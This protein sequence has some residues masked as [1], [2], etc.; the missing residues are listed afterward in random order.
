MGVGPFLDGIFSQGAFGIVTQM[1]I[2]LAPTPERVEA[3][4]F[5][6]P[7]DSDMERAVEAVRGLSREVG[8]ALGLVNLL[9]A[10]RVLSMIEPYPRNRLDQ[11]GLIDEQ[12][13][14]NMARHNQV[15]PWMGTGAI[16]GNARVVRAVK[17]VIK[18]KLS[19]VV[20]RLAFSHPSPSA[21]SSG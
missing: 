14:A 17:S 3:F 8:G 7:H 18:E 15:M 21:I 11:N 4:F 16:Y 1:T 2:A 6:L 12:Y 9:N 19:G 10:R 20:R 5:G 13:L